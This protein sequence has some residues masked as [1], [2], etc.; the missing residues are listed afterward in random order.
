M[1]NSIDY[2]ADDTGLIAL[3]TKGVTNRPLT[4]PD[5]GTRTL[6]KY[7]NVFLPIVLVVGYGA[8]RYQRRQ[9]QRRV[10][11]QMEVPA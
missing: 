2:L 11:Q 10:W 7:L 4:M 9:A 8:L 6:L 5:P 3:R 1:L